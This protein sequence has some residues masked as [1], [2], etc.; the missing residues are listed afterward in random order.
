MVI[1]SVLQPVRLISPLENK[2]FP[3]LQRLG[4]LALIILSVTGCASIRTNVPRPPS[5][6]FQ[7]PE[8]TKLGKTF[9]AA[10]KRHPGES[11][12]HILEFGRE[13]LA[14]RAALADAA[15]RTI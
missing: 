8:E 1:I 6:A 3:V 5:Y 2:L 10:E 13:A 14:A 12:F 4:I 7:H 15:E 9:A 11:G